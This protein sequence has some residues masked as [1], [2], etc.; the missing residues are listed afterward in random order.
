M[1]SITA[2]CRHDWVT[3][4]L[5][6]SCNFLQ[7]DRQL[8]KERHWSTSS[9]LQELPA[10]IC[11]LDLKL[12]IQTIFI[13]TTKL[14]EKHLILISTDSLD[15]FRCFKAESCLLNHWSLLE[16]IMAW[17][18]LN[19]EIK[20]PGTEVTASAFGFPVTDDQHPKDFHWK[21]RA[22]MPPWLFKQQLPSK[23]LTWTQQV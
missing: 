10:V 2:A 6:K 4:V 9:N 12:L 16:I 21:C 19:P 11:I 14:Q 18:C 1:I 7:K 8:D 23:S 17:G 22:V 13:R 20:F 15:I 5:W 3:D